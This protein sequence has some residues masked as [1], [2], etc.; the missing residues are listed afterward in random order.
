[1]SAHKRSKVTGSHLFGRLAAMLATARRRHRER[2]ELAM[3][4]DRD[5]HDAG[6]SRASIAYELNKPFW[7]G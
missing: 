1:M 5:L 3:L 2:G 7:R 6:L 4:D